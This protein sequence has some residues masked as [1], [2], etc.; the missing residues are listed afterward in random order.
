MIFN[1]GYILKFFKKKVH[2][3]QYEYRRR[4]PEI[5]FIIKVNFKKIRYY[6]NEEQKKKWHN[7]VSYFEEI[8]IFY[9]I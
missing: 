5:D 7:V 2:E 3:L 6:F 8:L 9:K 1:G 4:D